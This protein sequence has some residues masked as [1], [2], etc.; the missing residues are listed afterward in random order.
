MI[1]DRLTP[2]AGS[3]N[4]RINRLFPFIVFQMYRYFIKGQMVC[5][6][7]FLGAKAASVRFAPPETEIRTLLTRSSLIYNKEGFPKC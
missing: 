4:H 1:P 7:Q 2:P 3:L 6:A 5:Q